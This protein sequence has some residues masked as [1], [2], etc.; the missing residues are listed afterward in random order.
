LPINPI[1]TTLRTTIPPRNQAERQTQA[2][3]APVLPLGPYYTTWGPTDCPMLG[4]NTPGA[5]GIL[6]RLDVFAMPIGI[7]Y[8]VWLV[9]HRRGPAPTFRLVVDK[10]ELPG[11]LI[12]EGRRFVMLGET[13]E[14]L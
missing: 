10:F 8:P 6:A 7:A 1:T 3:P 13:A 2:Q 5:I 4:D 9:A 12:C 11:R 14:E